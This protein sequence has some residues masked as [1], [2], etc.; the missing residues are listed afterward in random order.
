MQTNQQ[1]LSST[2]PAVSCLDCRCAPLGGMLV[3]TMHSRLCVCNSA[4]SYCP[5]PLLQLRDAT[6][7]RQFLVQCLVLL[8]HLGGNPGK[9]DKV[10][11][12]AKFDGLEELRE[13]VRRALG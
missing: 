5:T 10:P 8:H 13:K 9:G 1:Q 2:C 12:G 4:R 11:V 3:Y 6:F 7:R